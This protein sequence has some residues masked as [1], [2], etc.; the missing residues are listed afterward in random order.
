M[1]GAVLCNIRKKNVVPY[2]GT[3]Y[4]SILSTVYNS[5]GNTNPADRATITVFDGDCN[6]ID[7]EYLYYRKWVHNTYGNSPKATVVYHFT[8]ESDIDTEHQCGTTYERVK[9]ARNS[10]MIQNY[11]A[12]ITYIPDSYHDMSWTQEKPMYQY[13][14]A[15]SSPMNAII[16]T[17]SEKEEVDT[18]NYDYRVH[19]SNVKD[20]N[21][22]SDSWLIFQ[23]IN[24]LDVD[25][26][27]GSITGLRLF[28]NKLIYWQES[29]TGVLSVNERQLVQN[30]DDT[31]LMLG[32]G[33]T[34][35]RFDYVS[36][37]YGMGKDQLSDTQTNST[38]YWWDSNKREILGY[39]G[40]IA[41]MTKTNGLRN[42]INSH[43]NLSDRNVS[44]AHDDK[45]DE[46]L[47]NVVDGGSIVFNE[48]TRFFTSI[49]EID[50]KHNVHF[51]DKIIL[52]TSDDLYEWNKSE[53]KI[54]VFNIVQLKPYVKY[55][56]N[57]NSTYNKVYDDISFGGRFYGGGTTDN[58]QNLNFVF[59]TPLKQEGRAISS[60]ITNREYDF[61][62]SMPR[63]GKT[64]NNEW[65]TSKY[66]DRLKGKSMQCELYSNSNSQD[67]S[68]QYIITKFRISWI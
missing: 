40:Q 25:T 34:L 22:S 16:S 61:R 1:F 51:N 30:V 56:V 48:Q 20:N 67:F 7:F 6:I 53:K 60:D 64:E 13:N 9:N 24:Y 32:T 41:P 14:T 3:S 47:F 37:E 50:F 58:V 2:G 35:Q 5:Y 26:R 21:E 68:L 36:T 66:G 12:D 55:V 15:Y 17:G 8:V 65:V 46:I 33:D 39:G 19:Y 27:Y 10:G 18:T 42:Y 62:L 23:P 45:Y 52:G 31:T 44:V 4:N 63:A 11:A 54:S 29:A 28:K 49:Y 59:K 57:A 38:L 43:Q